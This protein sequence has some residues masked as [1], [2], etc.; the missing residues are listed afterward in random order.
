MRREALARKLRRDSVLTPALYKFFT[1]LLTYLICATKNRIKMMAQ[2]RKV[3]LQA[4]TAEDNFR[5][6]LACYVVT[7][8]CFYLLLIFDFAIILLEQ[9]FNNRHN[10]TNISNAH[11]VSKH[12]ESEAQISLSLVSLKT[13]FPSF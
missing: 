2:Q 3:P 6:D 1:Y 9:H 13:V 4:Y 12:T 8:K 5:E 10:N 11:R 7:V